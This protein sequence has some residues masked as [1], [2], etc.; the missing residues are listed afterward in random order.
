MIELLSLCG[1]G[2]EEIA[3]E[4]S[5][6]EAVFNRLGISPADI[7]Q[8]KKRLNKYFDLDL[9]GVRKIFRLQV[10]NLV[11]LV[12]A[13]EEGKKKIIYSFMAPGID[14]IGLALMKQSRDVH[15]T[16]PVQHFMNVL[17]FMFG[18]LVPLLH[19]AEIKWL[20]AGGV[21]HCAHVKTILGLFALDLIPKPDLLITSGF[22]CEVAPKTIELLNE[23]YGVPTCICDGC[24]DVA[25]MDDPR[26]EQAVGLAAKSLRAA[27]KRMQQVTG[28]DLTDDMISDALDARGAFD[29]ALTR[30]QGLIETSDPMPLSNTHRPLFYRLGA[31]SFRIDDIPDQ[32]AVLNTLYGELEER[33]KRGFGAF[34]KGAP[35]ILCVLPAHESDPRFEHVL[36]E[37]GIAAVAVEGRFFA[38]DGGYTL[39]TPRPPDP[40]EALCRFFHFSIFET[41]KARIAAFVA[42]CRRLKVDGVLDRYHAG[43]RSVA[44]DALLIRE[45]VSRE[46]GLP[47]LVLDWENFDP[48]S[49]NEEQ[50]RNRFEQFKEMLLRRRDKP[51]PNRL[52]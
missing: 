4:L 9:V 25:S 23:F 24:R 8:A 51:P 21:A 13:R 5:R 14:P 10:R 26:A 43:C 42:V 38:P 3:S 17:G 33:V 11:D 45:A 34:E 47:V 15:V 48:R 44:G 39:D 35:R 46:L 52:Q 50:Y 49:F 7:D 12:L 20:K 40:Y 41:S 31:T 16:L 29:N 27:S 22:L 37:M 18:K 36:D 28:V 2:P 30:I 1:F 6:V 32:T 19:A